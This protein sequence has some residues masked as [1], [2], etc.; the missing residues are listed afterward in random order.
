MRKSDPR[1]CALCHKALQ[2]AEARM[3]GRNPAG[4]VSPRWDLGDPAKVGW[5]DR[6]HKA[7]LRFERESLFRKDMTLAEFVEL[8][9]HLLERAF[10]LDPATVAAFRAAMWD[11]RDGE[12]FLC[13]PSWQEVEAAMA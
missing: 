10:S 9:F 2:Y 7:W 6:H 5:S 11:D 13:H 8:S 1:T 3:Y 4:G 12:Q